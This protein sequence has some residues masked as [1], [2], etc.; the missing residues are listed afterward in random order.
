MKNPPVDV[1][2]LGAGAAGLMAAAELT[3]AGRRVTVLEARPRL[4]GRIFPLSAAVFGYPAE[5]GAEY[6]HGAAPLTRGLLAEAGLSVMP[7][8]GARWSL[9]DGKW[10]PREAAPHEDRFLAA[11]KALEADLPVAEFVARH[12]SGADYTALR[13]LID[14][15]VQGYNNADPQ[16]FSTFA[17]RDQWLDPDAERQERVV[18]GYGALV[19]FLAVR[20]RGRGGVIHLDA[21]IAAIEID[22]ERVIARTRDNRTYEASAAVLTAPLRVLRTLPLPAPLPAVIAAAD[23]AIGFGNVVKL[24][25]RFNDRWWISASGQFAD[26]G[27]AF[28]AEAPVPVW[29]TQYPREHAVLTGWTSAHKVAASSARSADEWLALGLESLAAL[30]GRSVEEL[31]GTLVASHVTRWGDDPFARGAYSYPTLET[32]AALAVLRDAA[33]GPIRLAGEALYT[34]GETGTVE[35]ALASGQAAARSLI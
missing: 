9:L 1:L 4:G 11:M 3:R 14:R 19:D 33:S 16:R 13:Q 2:I 8:A 22:G 28:G 21:E 34:E 15:E 5:A 7:V 20:V 32:P 35:A 18:G 31:H 24:H 17:L 26:L 10:V 29:W 30:F 23:D 25:L 12:F 27:F 6:I